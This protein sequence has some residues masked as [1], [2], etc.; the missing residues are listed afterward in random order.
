MWFQ[1]CAMCARSAC[2][3]NKMERFFFSESGNKSSFMTS[4]KLLSHDRI[5]LT[6]KWW[7]FFWAFA[8]SIFLIHRCFFSSINI[9]GFFQMVL[10]RFKGKCECVKAYDRFNVLEAFV[11][12]VFNFERKKKWS[13]LFIYI[14]AFK[15]NLSFCKSSMK[16]YQSDA[17]LDFQM[18]F[19]VRDS[20]LV[21]LNIG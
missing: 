4:I 9:R 14:N 13:F 6:T 16:K 2:D 19:C 18:N 7:T 12:Y 21:C 20:A 17:C 8:G 1:I 11:F 15:W 5:Y 10:T 3:N